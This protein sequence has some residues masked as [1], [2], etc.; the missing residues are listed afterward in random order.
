MLFPQL[1]DLTFKIG[2]DSGCPWISTDLLDPAV[3][4][5]EANAGI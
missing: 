4:L 3:Q 2:L 5:R 1:G